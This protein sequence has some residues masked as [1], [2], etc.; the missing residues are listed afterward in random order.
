MQKSKLCHDLHRARAAAIAAILAREG[1]DYAQSKAVSKAA[2]QRTGLR[3]PAERRVGIDR[4]TVEEELRFLDQA[5][6]QAAAA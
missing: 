5:Y 2:R 6:G 1:V 3:A 4:L